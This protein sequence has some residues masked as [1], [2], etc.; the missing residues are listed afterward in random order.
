M[1]LF[2]IIGVGLITCFLV[3]VIKQL[4]PEM[5]IFVGIAGGLIIIAMIASSL[6]SI[7]QVF[8]NIAQKS[9]LSSNLYSCLLKIIG[10]GYITEFASNICADS[11]ANSVADKM[12][13]AGKILILSVALP[14][15]TSI[16]EIIIE[17]LP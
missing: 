3:V 10:I 12:L 13:L 15:V 11:G 8:S 9:G 17:L 2:K 4:K 6:F 5:A 14:V 7:L 16:L 1:E